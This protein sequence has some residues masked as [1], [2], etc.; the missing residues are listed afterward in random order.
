MGLYCGGAGEEEGEETSGSEN[1]T[2]LVA[3]GPP[4]REPNGLPQRDGLPGMASAVVQALRRLMATTSSH[5]PTRMVEER[6]AETHSG[7]RRAAEG[8]E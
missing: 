2:C 3:A 4:G 7:R 5:D 6:A 1:E 8:V